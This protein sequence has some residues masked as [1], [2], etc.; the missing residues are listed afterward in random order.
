MTP[1]QAKIFM[2]A[3]SESEIQA[4]QEA[5]HD[6]VNNK[7]ERGIAVTASKLTEALQRFG[8]NFFVNNFLRQ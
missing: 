1:Y 8:D 2:Y 3:E 6:L 7:R 4:F 5:F